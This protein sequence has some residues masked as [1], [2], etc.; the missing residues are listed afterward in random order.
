MAIGLSRV[1]P[2]ADRKSCSDKQTELEGVYDV[3]W[4]YH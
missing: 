3:G 1:S 4:K 2:I